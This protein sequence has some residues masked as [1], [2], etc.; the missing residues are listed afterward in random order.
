MTGSSL[1]RKPQQLG[2]CPLFQGDPRSQ[3]APSS[4]PKARAPTASA[5]EPKP[6]EALAANSDQT[7]AMKE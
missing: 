1:I 2:G 6:A 3:E 7:V 5:E 4:K